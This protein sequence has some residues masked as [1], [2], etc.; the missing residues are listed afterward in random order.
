MY[1]YLLSRIIHW[2]ENA[3]KNDPNYPH[4]KKNILIFMIG[5]VAYLFTAGFL[6]S[7]QYASFIYS[8]LPLSII[9]D[10]FLW[11]V[12]IDVLS[13]FI[14]FKQFWGWSLLSELDGVVDTKKN[15]NI[16]TNILSN[17]INDKNVVITENNNIELVDTENNNTNHSINNSNTNDTTDDSTFS[18]KESND[19]MLTENNNPPL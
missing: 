10:F 7:K 1:Y 13:C 11:F 2:D 19:T 4:A 8:I 18:E 3:Q 12:A 5:S 6:W 14:L 9:K 17:T 15:K 16:N